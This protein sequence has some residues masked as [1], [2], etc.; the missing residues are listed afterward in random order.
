MNDYISRQSVLQEIERLFPAHIQGFGTHASKIL[1]LYN[2]IK[3][4]PTDKE[5][6][7]E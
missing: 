3:N 1:E 6:E 5:E 4:M 7:E 2:N